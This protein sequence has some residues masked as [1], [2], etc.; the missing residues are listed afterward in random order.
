MARFA[1]GE[2]THVGTRIPSPN[3]STCGGGTCSK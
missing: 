3:A 1:N 2:I